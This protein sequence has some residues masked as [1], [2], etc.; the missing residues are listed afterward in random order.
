MTEDDTPRL[1]SLLSYSDSR[2]TFYESFKTNIIEFDII[3]ENV[4]ISNKNVIRGFHYQTDKYAQGKLLHVLNG[5]IND[6]LVDIRP[7]KDYGKVWKFNLKHT[8]RKL[9]FIPQ[10]YAH[11]YSAV[12]DNTI[13]SYKLDNL[14]NKNYES[15]FH[16]LSS[17]LNIDWGVEKYIISEK[18]ASLP[19]FDFIKNKLQ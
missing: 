12:V 10:G 7:G 13:V 17:R 16:P 2:G 4:C 1:I 6:V 11:G 8:D 14:Y 18:D 19:E 15:G 5:E 9:L 3:Q